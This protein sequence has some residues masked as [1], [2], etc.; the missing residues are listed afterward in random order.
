VWDVTLTEDKM[1]TEDNQAGV[2]SVAYTPGPHSRHEAR[3]TDF[4]AWYAEHLGVQ[5][6]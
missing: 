1:I 4:C 2:L 3:I 5:V 6:S